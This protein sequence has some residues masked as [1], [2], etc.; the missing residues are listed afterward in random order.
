MK[1]AQWQYL[2]RT[3]FPT[4]AQQDAVVI[5]PVASIEQH[6]EHL[7]VNT[8]ANNCHSV[9]TMAAES[10][11]S[12]PVLVLPVV[13]PGYSPHHMEHPG[14][15]TLG[16]D[17]FVRMLTEVGVCVHTHG[18]RK[19]LFLNGHG[20]NSAIISAMRLKLAAEHGIAVVACTYWDI[21]G[22]AAVWRSICETDKGFVGHAAEVETSLQLYLQPDLVD[23]NSA[24]WVPG[25]YGDPAHATK[26]K[27]EQFL[28]AA[29]TGLVALI[30]DLHSGDLEKR[31]EWGKEVPND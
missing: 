25:V 10:I 4:L 16:F 26:E 29:V 22:V 1:R 19:I 2:R 11:D 8:D 14:T 9:A 6:G 7:P 17:T 28:N 5:I 23:M 20:G 27:G 21:P 15:I 24:Q 30:N 13:W 12:F 18:F 31:L 3:D